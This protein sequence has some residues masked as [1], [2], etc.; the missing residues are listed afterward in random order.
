MH[1]VPE[2]HKVQSNS[3]RYFP[4]IMKF[5]SLSIIVAKALSNTKDIKNTMSF[6]R[7]YGIELKGLLLDPIRSESDVV[8]DNKKGQSLI[9]R[10]WGR[11]TQ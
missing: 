8:T 6:F 7:S 1:D 10:F 2:L 3:E 9:R 5:E 11:L 4:V